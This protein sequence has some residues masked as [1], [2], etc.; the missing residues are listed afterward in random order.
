MRR[1]TNPLTCRIFTTGQIAKI[2]SMA[3][4]T[5]AQWCNKGLLPCYRIPGSPDRRITR[6]ALIAFFREY[7]LPMLAQLEPSGVTSSES[8][9]TPG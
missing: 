7:N 9:A 2:C 4:R 3:P 1:D 8:T 5:V 6:T